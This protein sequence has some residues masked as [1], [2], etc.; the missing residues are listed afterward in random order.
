MRKAKNDERTLNWKQACELIGCSQSHF[1][2]LVNTGK[3]PSCRYGAVRGVR[4][5]EAACVQYVER[6]HG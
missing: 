2:N 3:I 5:T 4:V 1:Y 6:M